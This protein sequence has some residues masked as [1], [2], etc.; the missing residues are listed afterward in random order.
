MKAILA[1]LALVAVASGAE[2]VAV[3]G[4]FGA[5]WLK[6]QPERFSSGS[7][8]GLW[9]WGHTPMGYAAE[10]GSLV[11]DV[12]N[13]DDMYS[14]GL[15]WIDST[16]PNASQVYTLPKGYVDYMYP[17]YSDDPWILAQHYGIPI[18]TDLSELP[19]EQQAEIRRAMALRDD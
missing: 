14:N 8:G 6:A 5:A 11:Q 2:P 13:A 19:E 12:A 7:G 9:T 16:P 1:L 18:R 17:F 15:G 10:N 3:G 4:D